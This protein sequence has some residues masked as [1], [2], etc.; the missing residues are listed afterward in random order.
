MSTANI[1]VDIRTSIPFKT[2]DD[3]SYEAAKAKAD[4]LIEEARKVGAT[5]SKR[6]V[7]A[8]RKDKNLAAIARG[9]SGT[10]EQTTL[11]ER[12]QTPVEA[13]EAEESKTTD[14]PGANV[15]EPE[16]AG[17]SRSF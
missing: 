7:R 3:G 4:A 13:P 14:G 1:H 8:A 15:P 9:E 10:D 6:S 12:A 2:D 16:H 5:K 17:P 11:V